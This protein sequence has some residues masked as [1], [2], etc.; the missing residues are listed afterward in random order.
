MSNAI[1][2][3]FLCLVAG[4]SYFYVYVSADKTLAYFNVPMFLLL[5]LTM[6]IAVII[7]RFMIKSMPNLF[8]KENLVIV[9][10][11]LFTTVTVCWIYERITNHRNKQARR[12]FFEDRT[13][14]NDL[15]WTH[16]S[17][18]YVQA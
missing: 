16:T 14:E 12:T 10:V 2:A 3:V 11:L 4:S 1:E 6:L 8:P 15:N 13:D 5:N 7:M 18:A 17:V 9:H